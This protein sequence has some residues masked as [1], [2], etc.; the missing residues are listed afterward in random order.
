MNQKAPKVT[1]DKDAGEPIWERE[2]FPGAL[3]FV[4]ALLSIVLM[5][6]GWSEAFVHFKHSYV[7]IAPLKLSLEHWVADG[8]MAVF[9]LFVSLELK[10][11]LVAGVLSKPANAALPT[12]AAL[13]GILIPAA[14]YL[15]MT[16]D[17]PYQQGWAITSATDIAFS[18]GVLSLF[19]DR[20]PNMLK[21]F[22]LA[23]AIVDDLGAVL[24]IAFGYTDDIVAQ[25]LGYAMAIF[26]LMMLCNR[27]GVKRLEVY[28]ILGLGLWYVLLQSGLHATIAGVL[29]AVAVPF[30]KKTKEEQKKEPLIIAEHALRPYVQYAIMPIYALFVAGFSLAAFNIEA[31]LHPVTLGIMAG[32]ILGKPLGVVGGCYLFRMISR[33]PLTIPWKKIIGVASLSGIGFTMSLFIGGLAFPDGHYTGDYVKVGVLI[34]SLMSGCIGALF[35]HMALPKHGHK[36]MTSP[37]APFLTKD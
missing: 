9:F 14:F 28:W 35:L 26:A 8:L 31:L 29:T 23:L 15:L 6:S 4:A 1:Y 17:T 5:N 2:W 36:H 13:G 7:G 21:A 33:R 32:L 19:G 22:L 34:G 24:I 16:M 27:M 25:F 18:L 30:R 11:E 12:A 37:S 20:V 10:R 3:L